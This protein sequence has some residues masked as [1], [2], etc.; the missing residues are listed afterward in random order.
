[1]AKN[2]QKNEFLEGYKKLH[3]ITNYIS[4]AMLYL[5]SNELLENEFKKENIKDRILGH[6]GTVPGLNF[7]YGGLNVLQKNL[8]REMILVAGPGHGAPAILSNLFIEKT[9]SEYYPEYTWNK[10]GLK[11]LIHDFSWPTKFPSH[12]SAKVPG[13]ILEGGELGYSLATAFGTVFDNPDLTAVCV[14]GDGEAETGTLSSS[15]HLNKFLTPNKDG[16]VLPILHLNSYR[17]SGPTIFGTMSREEIKSYFEGLGYKPVFVDQFKSKDIYKDFLEALNKSYEEIDRVK[18][19][20]SEYQDYKPNWPIIILKTKKGW[21][22]VKEIHG[23]IIEDNNLSHG[24]PLKNPKNS[25]DEFKALKK[26]LES[27]KVEELIES[28]NLVDRDILRIIPEDKFKLGRS[29][30]INSEISKLGL[31]PIEDHEFKI[32][33]RGGRPDSNTEEVSH[34]IRDV[35]K[36]NEN[37]GNFRLFSPDE[38][39]SNLIEDI[40][41]Q[42]SKVYVWPVHSHDKFYSTEGGVVELLSENV[43]IQAQMGYALTGRHGLF[44]SYEAFINIISSQIDQFLKYLKQR[45][46]TSWRKDIPSLN[47]ISTSTLWRQEHN[48]YT[49]Q[50]PTLINSLLAKTTSFARLY[51]PIDVNSSLVL[52]YKVLASKNQVN[53]ITV[54]KRDKPQWLSLEESKR[55]VEDGYI[56]MDW[57]SN[58]DTSKE[59]VVLASSGDYQ[60]LENLA[61]IDLLNDLIPE[62]KLKVVYFGEISHKGLGSFDNPLDTKEKLE[63]VLTSDRDIIFNFHGYPSAIESLMYKFNIAGRLK[64][65][66]YQEQGT[67]TTPFDMQILN[68]TSRYHIAIECLKSASKFNKKVE[69]EKEVLIDYFKKKI[70]KHKKYIIENGVDMPEVENWKWVD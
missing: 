28:K 2:K 32:F 16:V 20:W 44:I 15:W 7:I 46:E 49:H 8:K 34:Y 58:N 52:I 18:A 45:S 3:R 30:Y 31:P 26:W 22:G 10:E 42:T 63:E 11:K 60:N 61:A 13:S 24:I 53:L 14:V 6:W 64:V 57:A 1:M 27:Y 38:S 5:K 9:L 48:G 29:K 51:F 70:E 19:E 50:N 35:F 47:I 4:A 21:S 68:G 39:E 66:G 62:L 65:F 54:D 59:D 12:T 17:I 41:D 55:L 67:T 36:Y 40:F 56:E 43:L 37:K 23:E 69:E 25:D 33:Q